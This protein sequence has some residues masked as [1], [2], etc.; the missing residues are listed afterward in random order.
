MKKLVSANGVTDS[1]NKLE[2][3]RREN[4]SAKLKNP[5]AKSMEKL[6]KMLHDDS[7]EDI[8]RGIARFLYVPNNL[9]Q[10][11]KT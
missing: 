2:G 10:E 7:A 11:L 4:E 9:Q 1:L 5:T 6:T 8:F 3:S